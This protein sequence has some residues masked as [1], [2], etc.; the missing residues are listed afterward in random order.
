M[1]TLRL[2]V[3]D[4]LVETRDLP[5]STTLLKFLR[6]RLGLCGAK[7]GCAEGDCGA[8]TVVV[9]DR[10][11][12]GTPCFR[13]VN[14]CLVLL[15]MMQGRRVY[16]VEA[17]QQ[18]GSPHVI[19]EAMAKH[20]GSQCGYCT[21]GVVMSLVEATYRDDLRE[22]WQLDDQLAGN[23]C[24]CTGYR[25]IREVAQELASSR[26]AD[27]FAERL[28]R[29]LEPR[30]LSYERAGKRYFSPGSLK[31]LFAILAAHPNA[32]I[33][34]GGTDL[35]LEVTKR[36]REPEALVSVEAVPEL[37]RVERT[38]AGWDVGAAVTLTELQETLEASVTPLEKMLRVFASRQIRNRA[39]VG[40][41]LCNASPIGDLAP[42]MLALGAELSL[43][44]AGGTRRIPIERF[45]LGYRKTALEPGEILSTVHL[46][47]V[48]EGV[49]ASSYKVSKRRE[50]DISTVAMGAFV[51]LSGDGTASDVRLGYGGMAAT[52]ARAHGTEAALAGKPWTEASVRAATEALEHDFQPISD[53]RGSAW[54]RMAVAK[55]LLVGF[56]FETGEGPV[57][58][59]PRPTSTI[60]LRARGA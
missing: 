39:T 24:R 28:H 12:D 22:G 29:E 37:R 33:V 56:Y 35:A 17:L 43:A 45:F 46:P 60:H 47:R 59:D 25:A 41:N 14:S 10:R 49:R 13:A 38:A 6:E 53:A 1:D 42:V 5:P 26:P 16:T 19:Q 30:R 21:P 20:Q 11:L 58:L 31:E 34:A 55:N 9:Q 36:F 57:A 51:R 54:Y 52:P 44:S 2:T 40:G 27:A 3:N 18:N 7:E 8:C 32:R 50:L 23:I 15:P 48:P 4:E